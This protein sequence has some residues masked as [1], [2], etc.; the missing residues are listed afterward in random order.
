MLFSKAAVPKKHNIATQKKVKEKRIMES[1]SRIKLLSDEIS[2]YYWVMVKYFGKK[3][4]SF[5]KSNFIS[6]NGLFKYVENILKE[7]NILVQKIF[8]VCEIENEQI[9]QKLI[10]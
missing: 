10:E 5:C 7:R 8:D 3:S 6:K 9:I 4:I 2:P 1:V